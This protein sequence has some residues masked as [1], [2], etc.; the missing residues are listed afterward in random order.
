MKR[1]HTFLALALV[2]LAGCSVESGRDSLIRLVDEPA[3]ANCAS[4]G[5]RVENGVDLDADGVL[6]ASEVFDVSYLCNGPAGSDGLSG[7]SGASG[8]SGHAAVIAQVPEAAGD[9]CPFG[10][11]A[12]QSGLDLDDDGVLDPAEVTAI[13]YV[14]NG[15]AGDT[16]DDAL[17]QVV[18][19]APGEHCPAGG[20]AIYTG[21]DL[22]GDGTLSY[23]EVTAVSYVCSGA[24]GA[25]GA[26]GT[27]GADGVSCN[28]TVSPFG[29]VRSVC[30]D[31]TYA[32]LND[33]PLAPVSVAT[34]SFTGG[35]VGSGALDP[36][37]QGWMSEIDSQQPEWIEYDFGS[38]ASVLPTFVQGY[39]VNGRDGN[40]T[41]Q[42]SNDG[43]TWVDLA[44]FD[45]NKFQ[46][47]A[48]PLGTMGCGYYGDVLPA[49]TD[50]GYRFVRAYSAGA[51][52]LFYSWLQFRGVV[53]F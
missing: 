46:F 1:H 34:S 14:C 23:E 53:L 31:G 5:Q 26:S 9:N 17:V 39:F 18:D 6:D 40:P 45:W 8:A 11:Q 4:G 36:D 33:Q 41:F 13:A 47:G 42:G 21:T 19:E 30:T 25:D 15:A 38:G 51:P 49:P 37:F 35:W 43:A 20:K 7:S 24:A 27:D 28:L 29:V 22:N 10:G 48:G 3:G 12:V 44:V 32:V 16:G 50:V 2:G 52:Y